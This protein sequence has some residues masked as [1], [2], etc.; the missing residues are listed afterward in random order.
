MNILEVKNLNMSY[1]TIDGDVD[2]VKDVSF[3]VKEG[4]SFGI[5]G[6]SGCG[7]T[8]VAM[9]LLQLQADNGRITSGEIKFDGKDIVELNESELREVRW[10]GISIVFQGAMNSWN[11]V[12]KIGEQIREAIREHYPDKSKEDN[13]KK[14]IE[15][16]DIVGLD[17]T[18]IDRFPHELS[19]GMKQRAVIALALSC[20]PKLIIADEPTTALDVVIQDQIL[21]EIRKVQ[22]VLGLSLIYISHDIAV[23]AEM[24]DNMAVMYAGSIVEMGNTAKVFSNPQHSYTRM[25]LESTPSIVGPKKKLRSLDG[26]P[27]SL[28]NTDQY[29]LFSYRCPNPDDNCKNR[30]LEMQLIKIEDDHYADKCCVNCG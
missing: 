7:K 9:S 8:S 14:I 22:D 13:T 16:F 28:I 21:K 1:K 26:E 20:D 25:L 15:L 29:C 4:E 17:S 30:S 24:T 5:V 6:E 27:P 12:V 18:I 19:G 2:A 3:T 11:P 23:I 10:S